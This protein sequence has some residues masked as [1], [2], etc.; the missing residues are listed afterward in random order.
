MVVQFAHAQN[1]R[2]TLE[3]KRKALKKEIQSIKRFLSNT[4]K[5]ELDLST[6]VSVMNQ[7]MRVRQNLIDNIRQEIKQ[8]KTK[9][10]ANQREIKL[11]ET[12]LIQLK[13]DYAAMIYKSYKYKLNDNQLLFLLSSD[14]FYQGYLRYQ[15][16]KQYTDYRKKQG[17]NI[18]LKA[19][20]LQAVNDS[21]KA[22][23]ILK[24][25]LMEDMR[26]EQS[27]MQQEKKKQQELVNKYK[28][29]K[30][31]Y[32][33]QIS[34][35]QREERQLTAQIESLIKKAIKKTGNKTNNT[36]KLAP[37]A[38]KLAKDFETN[39]G[40]LPW[41]VDRGVITVRFG[42]QKDPLNPKL[43]IESSGIRIATEDN[44]TVKSIFKG[45]VLAIQKNPQN[46]VLSVLVQHGHYIS[47]YA[48]L[49]DVVV[50]RGQSIDT[51][52]KIGVVYTNPVD[53]KSILKFQIWKNTN[54][55]N[56]TLWITK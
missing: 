31:S 32:E 19:Q 36:F 26:N 9:L 30:K 25:N 41:P 11:L 8:L 18:V 54:K 56:P 44:A 14:S 53:G 33:R 12:E 2:Q 45:K 49:K 42:T 13:E 39:K 37:E 28:K 52:E 23:K 50:S 46:G 35:K 21:I 17:E 48:N 10:N 6:Q 27:A 38:L 34:A 43:K 4:K 24:E 5:K 3:N 51:K 16:L 55:Q 7:K 22:Q 29:E 15:Y 40:K 20:T 47:V 1:D